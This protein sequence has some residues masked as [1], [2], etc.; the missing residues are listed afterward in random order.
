M[1]LAEDPHRRLNPLTNEWV[2]VSP[3]RA[4]RPWQGQLE[5]V[6]VHKEPE[7]DP[8]CYLCPGNSRAGGVVNPRYTNTFVFD[9]DFAALQPD[10]PD[11]KYE[12][13]L[14]IAEGDPGS[15]AAGARNGSRS[16]NAAKTALGSTPTSR[17]SDVVKVV[18]V[19]TGSARLRA[20]F[21]M[22]GPVP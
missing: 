13:G 10:A 5:N 14:L 1:K 3:H 8:S 15:G 19:R 9:N 18:T 7:Y 4:G 16:M 21:G 11:E 17:A 12:E 6:P 2:L 20:P 22:K